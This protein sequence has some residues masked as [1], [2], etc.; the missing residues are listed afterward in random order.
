[1]LPKIGHAVPEARAS[2]WNLGYHARSEDAAGCLA[3][4][5]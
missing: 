5:F 4:E 1:M 2:A 3:C